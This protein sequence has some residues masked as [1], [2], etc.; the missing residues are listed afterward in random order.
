MQDKFDFIYSL[1]FW[2]MVIGALS[3]YLQTKGYIG[4]PEMAL[5]ATITAGFVTVKTIDRFGEKS[6]AVDTGAVIATPPPAKVDVPE[7]QGVKEPKN[8]LPY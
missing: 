6:G 5:I 4:E 2:S 7:D 3:I 1:R 8:E